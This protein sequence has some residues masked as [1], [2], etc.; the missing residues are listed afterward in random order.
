MTFEKFKEE[1]EACEKQ[2]V[3]SHD[4][5]F[6]LA[7]VRRAFKLPNFYTFPDTYL[8]G[9]KK[10]KIRFAYIEE[11]S[12]FIIEN[13]VYEQLLSHIPNE[14]KSLIIAYCFCK[15]WG[16]DYDK[17]ANIIICKPSS[18]KQFVAPYKDQLRSVNEALNVAQGRIYSQYDKHLEINT[19]PEIYEKRKAKLREDKLTEL[20]SK[21][22]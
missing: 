8:L 15:F 10:S 2:K 4:F 14:E 18:M 16:M 12:V 5:R 21:Q 19:I 9:E 13:E 7:E 1:F 3:F 17:I 11:A 6:V 22:E 20:L